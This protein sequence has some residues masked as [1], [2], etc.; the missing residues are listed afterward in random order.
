MP[1]GRTAFVNFERRYCEA[2]AGVAVGVVTPTL[3]SLISKASSLRLSGFAEAAQK[4]SV[5]S[6]GDAAVGREIDIYL[7]PVSPHLAR[8]EKGFDV[9]RLGG[10]AAMGPNLNRHFFIPPDILFMN[11]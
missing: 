11:Q 6:D 3:Y 7:N 1:Y 2:L 9:F 4:V 10:R 5:M 8:H